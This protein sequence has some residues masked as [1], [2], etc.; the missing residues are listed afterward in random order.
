MPETANSVPNEV[1]LER[2]VNDIV[3]DKETLDEA[4]VRQVSDYFRRWTYAHWSGDPAHISAG[5]PRLKSCILLDAETL[6]QLQTTP[7]F[8]PNAPSRSQ[9]LELGGCFW[10][11]IVEAFPRLRLTGMADC[12]R[13]LLGD[14]AD[15][16]FRRT[17]LD[18]NRS[19]SP[20]VDQPKDI[21]YYVAG[22]HGGSIYDQPSCQHSDHIPR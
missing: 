18:P 21:Y 16:W 10:V 19:S 14:L 8:I 11:K 2:F 1:L 3:E 4:T 7:Q 6:D 5:S 12:Y 20:V 22:R 9:G 15:F 17:W 13:L